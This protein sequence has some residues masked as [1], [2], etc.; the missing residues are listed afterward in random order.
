MQ[1]KDIMTPLNDL[2]VMDPKNFAVRGLERI[3]GDNK[4]TIFVCDIYDHYI[5]KETQTNC[6]IN[7]LKQF[8]KKTF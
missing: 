1:V 2:R 4:S 7:L 8:V 3:V 6:F 5:N